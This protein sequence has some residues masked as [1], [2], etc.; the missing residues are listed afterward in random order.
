MRAM[1][2]T[3]S[4][5]KRKDGFYAHEQLVCA[6]ILTGLGSQRA[7]VL[8]KEQATAVAR[9]RAQRLQIAGL[10]IPCHCQRYSALQLHVL[11]AIG[12]RAHGWMRPA[13]PP[14]TDRA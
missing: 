7:D 5:K 9:G 2:C 13:A 8:G 1:E 14:S 10:L 6:V 4:I 11:T 3:E 12:V